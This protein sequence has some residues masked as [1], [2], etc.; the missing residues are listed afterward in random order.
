M[1]QYL[2]GMGSNIE[3][4]QHLKSAADALREAFPEVIFSAVHRSA[5]IGMP[6]AADFLNA[7]CLLH[8]DMQ[9]DALGIW[10]KQL[11]DA[12]GRDR[13]GGS[14][15]PRTL[16]LDVLM[17][18]GNVVDDELFRYAHAYVLACELLSLPAASVDTSGLERVVLKLS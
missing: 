5:A 7:C 2:V 11:E 16:D 10:L 14:W 4:E 8:C 12:H 17:A 18:A 3:P 1:T 13:S 6:G 9:Q 15:K